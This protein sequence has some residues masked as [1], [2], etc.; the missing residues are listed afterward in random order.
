MLG[1]TKKVVVVGGGITGLTAAYYLQ[2]AAKTSQL[3]VAVTLI[4]ASP[5]LGGKI[6][7]VKK[8]G[9]IIEKGP[10]SFLTRKESVIRLIRETG[11]SGQLVNHLIGRSYAL[12]NGQLHAIPEGSAMGIP[13]QMMPFLKTDLFSVSGKVRAGLDFLLPRSAMKNDDSLGRFFRRRL[14]GEIV[15]NLIEPLL[16]VMYAGDIDKLSLMATFPQLHEIEQ[17]YRS[18]ILGMRKKT[19]DFVHQENSALATLEGGLGEL[20]KG[21]EEQLDQGTV[22]KGTRVEKIVQRDDGKFNLSL[23][24]G[25]QLLADSVIISTPHFTLPSMMPQC[26][27]FDELQEMPAIS[28]AA[29]HMAFHAEDVSWN[30]DGA[31]FVVSRN[32]DYT[33]TSCTWMNKKWPHT[34]PVGKVLLRCYV[35]GAGDEAIVD[36]SDAEIE[37]IVLD[38]LKKTMSISSKPEFTIVSR[39]KKAMPQYT[40][41]HTKRI[42]AIEAHIQ[43]ELPGLFIGGSSFRGISLPDCIEQGEE[44]AR[45]TLAFLNDPNEK[46]LL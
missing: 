30:M 31:G 25:Q 42:E 15:E 28:V 46:R 18:L 21:V 43:E 34:A 19:P 39:W 14:G 9:F 10:D 35:G 3:P 4:E 36:L 40:M 32:S 11:L 22:L 7:T 1:E 16:S 8:D 12:V 37:Q 38:D 20:V 24:S 17:K 44:A 23:N 41:G 26:R 6:Q 2:K 33:I 5:R 13:T 27:F 29:V 45:K